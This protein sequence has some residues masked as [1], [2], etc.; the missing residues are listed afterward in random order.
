MNGSR[1]ATIVRKDFGE[2]A[3]NPFFVFITLMVLVAWVAVFW[4]LPNSVDETVRVGISQSDLGNVLP[5]TEGAEVAGLALV[6]YPSEAELETAVADGD[7]DIVAGIAFPPEFL[8]AL[9]LALD[10]NTWRVLTDSG[11]DPVAAAAL[12]TRMMTGAFDR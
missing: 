9:R 5:V 11:L 3:R 7:D 12:I 1:I 6:P 4:F 10:F 2:F 8:A